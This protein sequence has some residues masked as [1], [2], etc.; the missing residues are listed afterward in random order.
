MDQELANHGIT[1]D[2][3]LKYIHSVVAFQFQI[4]PKNWGRLKLFL[5]KKPSN[6]E[7]IKYLRLIWKRDHLPT[8]F[9]NLIKEEKEQTI[10]PK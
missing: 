9:F 3:I 2:D 4:E 5:D 1:E 6:K 7:L 8:D 10:W